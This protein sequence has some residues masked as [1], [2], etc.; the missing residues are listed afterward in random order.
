MLGKSSKGTLYLRDQHETY[1]D[2]QYFPQ[3]PIKLTGKRTIDE[4]LIPFRSTPVNW[5]ISA[6]ARTFE[7]SMLFNS[8]KEGETWLNSGSLAGSYHDA[9]VSRSRTVPENV[10]LALDALLS[11]EE[12]SAPRVWLLYLGF[13]FNTVEVLID[14]FSLDLDFQHPETYSARM[15]MAS[16]R[17]RY[18]Y[19]L[20][21][22]EAIYRKPKIPRKPSTAPVCE[23]LRGELDAAYERIKQLEG[24]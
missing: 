5:D 21:D 16:V 12:V 18:H 13:P 11:P 24:T 19:E 3:P 7:F 23:D 15:M 22:P 1:L 20:P 8:F 2:F 4:R 9:I 6:G 17:G 10:I 14:D